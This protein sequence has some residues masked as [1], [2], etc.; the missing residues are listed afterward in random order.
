MRTVEVAEWK[1]QEPRQPP[2]WQDPWK[3]TRFDCMAVGYHFMEEMAF[4]LTSNPRIEKQLYQVVLF[5]SIS[6]Y[7][8]VA[9][10]PNP[11]GLFV[12]KKNCKK[13]IVPRL[14]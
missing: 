6:L 2:V 14:H 11:G 8:L 12:K 13:K 3:A 9:S 4:Y 10:N 5:L 7:S 1:W